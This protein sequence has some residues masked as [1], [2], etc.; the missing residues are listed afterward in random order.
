MAQAAEVLGGVLRF[1]PNMMIV[2]L[3]VLGIT[4]GRVTWI[5]VALGAIIVVIATVT[6]QNLVARLTS[7]TASTDSA[8]LEACSLIPIF[9]TEYAAT[10]SLWVALSTFFATYIFMNANNIY[11]QTPARVNKDKMA[12]QQRKGMG[13]ISMFAILILFVLIMFPRWRSTCETLL[14]MLT[15]IIIGG[16]GGYGWWSILHAC[17]SNV[18]P[19]IHGVMLGLNPE[20]LRTNPVACITNVK[21]VA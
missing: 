21:T 18:F 16:L 14:G 15:G 9:G 8:V 5:L 19:D 13:L 7:I 10:P 4:T 3:M 20:S 2:T 12:V 17:G 1:F 11:T 6:T